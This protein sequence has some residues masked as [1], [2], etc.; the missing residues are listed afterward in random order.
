MHRHMAKD[1]QGV[2]RR[3]FM[4]ASAAVAATT[5]TAPLA[6]R[7]VASSPGQS[8]Y[9]VGVI[10]CGGR[11]SGAAECAL[12]AHAGT[13]IVALADMFPDRLATCRDYL[14]SMGDRANVDQRR[15][16]TGFDAYQKLL[17][18]GG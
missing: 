1:E 15:C 18:S 7:A 10:G 13:R 8:E 6:R 12:Q 2:S 16:Y 3:D 11:G 17:D 9:R 14:K 4:R 5:L